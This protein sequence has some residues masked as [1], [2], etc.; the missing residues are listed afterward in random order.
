MNTPTL[1]VAALAVFSTLLCATSSARVEAAGEDPHA[2]HRATLHQLKNAKRSLADYQLPD[3]SLVR[4][5]GR[6]TTL[7][8][9]LDGGQPVVVDFIFTTCASICPI[10]SQNFSQLQ[11]KLGSDLGKVR[12]VSISIDPEQDTPARLLEY[13]KRYHAGQRWH[14]Y[15]GTVEASRAVQQAFGV[16][17]GDKMSHTP[18]TLLR[19]APGQ[20]W[21]RIDGFAT[22]GE[23]AK[24]VRDLV[25]AR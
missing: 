18:A 10:L 11:K 3:V 12:L 19:G 9:A 5:D 8:E 6:A 4:E 23:L 21:I 2:A 22:G 20:P 24:E 14:F 1:P 7:V 17:R 13:A 15:T 16:Y 25:A